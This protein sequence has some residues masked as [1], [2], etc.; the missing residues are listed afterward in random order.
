MG[1]PPS[2]IDHVK[3]FNLGTVFRLIDEHGPISRISLSK[4]AT[5]AP[6]SITKIT[7]ELVEAHLIHETEFPGLG[8]RGRPAVGLKLESKGW[9]FL[10]IRVNNGSL[11]FSLR[12]LDNQLVVE[13]TF[14]FPK[15]NSD[16]FLHH[17]L[18]AIDTFFQR[19]Q[20]RV[21]RLTAI[22]ITMNAIVDPISG[23]IYSS[24]YY[25]IQ[26]IPLADKIQEKTGVAVFLQHSVTAW[27]MA[28]SLY[29]AAKNN[30]DILQIVIDDIVGAGV[31]TNG[32]TLHS[33]SH[34]AVEI[35][36][37]KV[38]DSQTQCY[39]GAKG[40]LETEISIPQLIKKAQ[41]LAQE[42]PT[43]I[44]NQYPITVET[45]CDAVLIGD[46]QALDIINLVAQRLGFI[47]AVMVNIFN[48]QKI[49]IGSP[50][51]RAKS[52]LFP[53]ILSSIQHHVLPRYAHNLVIEET[54]LRN[55]GTLPA[56][57]LVKEALYNGS[58]LLELMQG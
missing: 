22:S 55:K 30:S 58:L 38:I 48:P 20:S 28:E 53:L 54:E 3:Q 29:G 37:T 14:D 50:L 32:K 7:R 33:N 16:A 10:C 6:A 26:D 8:F 13:D 17:F 36:H 1:I 49:L 15:Q 12:E 57:S 52:A 41:H 44:L 34:S 9:Q 40:C 5:L 18:A 25:A 27:T 24:P 4:K 39:C 31:V 23:V 46:K 11:L 56:A 19:Y 47:L 35:G 51:C 45:L 2:H 42:N 43:S 21:E